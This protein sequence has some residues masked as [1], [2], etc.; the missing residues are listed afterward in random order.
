M[1]DLEFICILIGLALI[2]SGAAPVFGLILVLAA[3]A[4]S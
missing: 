3:I 4:F 1:K 2:F